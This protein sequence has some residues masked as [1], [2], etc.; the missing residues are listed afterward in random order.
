MEQAMPK[1]MTAMDEFAV[2]LANGVIK[3]RW[4]VILATILLTFGIASGM[5]Y[6][7]FSNNYRDFFS[8]AN[9]ELQEANQRIQHLQ[10]VVTE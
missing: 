2:K 8:E 6:L 1:T 4:L 9:P 10:A 5:Q 7:G 3:R